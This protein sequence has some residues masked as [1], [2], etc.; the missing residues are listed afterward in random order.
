MQAWADKLADAEDAE[1]LCAI[2]RDLYQKEDIPYG[3]LLL[4]MCM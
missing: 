2:I 3:E 4:Q 1:A